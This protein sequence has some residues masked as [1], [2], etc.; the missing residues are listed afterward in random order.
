[1]GEQRAGRLEALY[2][3]EQ[4]TRQRLTL[5]AALRFDRA[6]SWF[7]AQLEGPSRFLPTP[8]S[9][10]ETRGVDSYKDVT[11]RLGVAY[12]LF[13]TGTTALKMSLGKYL[14]G[15]GVTGNYANT[16][17]S[18]RMPQTTQTFGT[19]GVT[20]VWTDANQ[21]FVPD[22]DL[23]NPAAQDLRDRGGDLCGLMSNTRFGTNV[24]TNN[25]DPAILN[26]WGVRASDWNLTAS[27]QQKIGPRSSADVTY[28]RRYHGFFVADNLSLQP[29]DLTPF[30]IEAP[31]DPRLPGGGGYVVSDLYDVVPEKSGQVNNLVTDSNAYGRWYQYFNG[32]DVTFNVRVGR[33]FVFVGGTSTGQTVAD[34][35]DV[36]AHLPELATT[37]TGT[38][39][40]GAGLA[41][42]AVTPLSPYCH[43]AFGIRTQFRGLSS[44]IL[45]RV[46]LQ[47]AA[48]FQSKPGAMLAAN[49][50]VPN[51]AVAPSLRRNLSGNATNV[52]VNLV[53]PGT[54]CGDHINQ[55]DLRVAKTLR[56]RGSRTLIAFDIYNSLNSSAVLSYNTTFVPNGPW[57]QPLTILTPRFLKIT[58]EVNFE[59][60]TTLT[61]AMDTVG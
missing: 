1:V 36:R 35:C 25:F 13:G 32:V 41:G 49:Y 55:L 20:R 4:W 9:I 46:D 57:L 18:L 14:E 22:C 27:I 51:S 8:I 31:L 2:L 15:A 29:S 45:P 58:A 6:R 12:D 60:Q 19:P 5:Q 10:P 50:A 24:L 30:S 38:S 53:A 54:M 59:P 11:P 17:P 61:A 40:F 28:R 16:N 37:T 56:C 52:T 44:Y 3:Q 47:V 42:S 33:D 21:N 39:A 48:T 7:P 26:G 23:S 43:V 34:N